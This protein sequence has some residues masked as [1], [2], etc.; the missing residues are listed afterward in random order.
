VK[1][2][3]LTSSIVVVLLAALAL[4]A[5]LAAQERTNE[6]HRAQHRR[7]KLV[8]IGTL[9]GPVSYF[10]ASGLGAAILNN[11]GTVA[12]Y[13]DT[14]ALDPNDPNNC[15]DLDCLLAHAFRWRDGVV[16]DLGA[17]PGV[18]SSAVSAINEHDW[19]AGFSQNGT[20]D[21]LTGSPEADAVLWKNHQMVNLGT[22]GG[23]ESLAVGMNNRGQIIGIATNAV[24][25]P[26]PFPF[27]LGFQGTQQRA[28]L[29]EKGV[30]RDLGTLGGPDAA[31]GAAMNDRGQ[32]TGSSYTSLTPNPATGLP[33]ADPFLWEDGK[34]IDLGSLGG[35]SGYGLA[36]NRRGQVAGQSNLAGDVV[37]HAFL[38]DKGVLRDLGTLGGTL[39]LPAWLNDEGETVG[40]A[41]TPGDQL[42]HAALWRDG[43]ITDLGTLNSDCFSEA[44]AINSTGQIVG[45]SLACDGITS[46][47]FV[48][49]DGS[50]VDLNTLIPSNSTLQL[51]F[52]QNINDR[53]EIAGIGV[54]SGSPPNPDFFGHIFLLIPC[55]DDH[56][57]D[58]GCEQEGTTSETQGSHAPVSRLTE[59]TRGRL[60][61]EMLAGLRAQFARRHRIPG[62][63][64]S[65][66]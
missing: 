47:A 2:K 25:D 1:S 58:A 28:F 66:F 39:S 20:I 14:S 37:S 48:W 61:P 63:G 6:E 16:T 60:T 54:P 27:G 57:N 40:G 52:A 30:L 5:R 10:S 29:W 34:M 23:N 21:P 18:T 24:P 11:R 46:E 7:Y 17:L 31:P 4:P 9:G 26:F 41:T 19:I 15:F 8:D 33:T 32:V 59:A 3:T 43:M 13:G 49:E 55:D 42:F 45:Q 22:L 38:W 36:V 51:L 35:T 53:G 50:M 56:S 12:G 62:L 64:T 44:L 65:R